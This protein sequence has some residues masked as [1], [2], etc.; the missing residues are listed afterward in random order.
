MR[1]CWDYQWFPDQLVRELRAQSL[2][3]TFPG[4]QWLVQYRSCGLS[5]A[6]MNPVTLLSWKNIG[7][8]FPEIICP[9]KWG[10][11]NSSGENES[12]AQKR[13]RNRGERVETDRYR[14]AYSQFFWVPDAAFLNSSMFK[15]NKYL[16]LFA[17]NSGTLTWVSIAWNKS[18]DSKFTV[19]STLLQLHPLDTQ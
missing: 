13:S 19:L 14:E 6:N 2:S 8:G 3:V 18:P 16:F 11:S 17:F 10:E 9:A 7:C 4:I 12:S 1:P 15:V 5:W